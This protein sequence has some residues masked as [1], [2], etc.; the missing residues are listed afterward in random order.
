MPDIICLTASRKVAILP[1]GT[2]FGQAFNN[3]YAVIVNSLSGIFVFDN[4]ISLVKK[5][6][7]GSPCVK[8]IQVTKERASP[9]DPGFTS[10][11]SPISL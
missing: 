7:V 4:D 1:M 2:S 6:Y 8:K 3:F 11:S 5:Y 9:L 10:S